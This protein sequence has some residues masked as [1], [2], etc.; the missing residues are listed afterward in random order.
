N[1][2]YNKCYFGFALG[3]KYLGDLHLCCYVHCCLGILGTIS[4]DD[5]GIS[6]MAGVSH[7]IRERT[8]ALDAYGN[9]TAAIGKAAYYLNLV[10]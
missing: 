6:E 3:Y 9:T 1:L 2:S 5:G 10:L 7:R 4:D 8:N